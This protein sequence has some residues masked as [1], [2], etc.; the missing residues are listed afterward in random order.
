MEF[1]MKFL[2]R[3]CKQAM[4]KILVKKTKHISYV[5]QRYKRI[6]S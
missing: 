1:I 5:A 3:W 2:K 6:K 4:G